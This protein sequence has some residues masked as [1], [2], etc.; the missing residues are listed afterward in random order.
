MLIR[1]APTMFTD[2]EYGCCTISSVRAEIIRN[3]KFKT[4]YPWRGQYYE[5][6][7]PLPNSLFSQNNSY[8]IYLDTVSVLNR[9]GTRN[10]KTDRL[11]DLSPVDCEI[12]ACALCNGFK[13][14]TG[15]SDIKD[16]AR[17]EFQRT[18]RGSISPLGLVN[19]WIKE[20]LI[21]WNGSFHNHLADWSR[22]NED[23]QPGR[24]KKMFKKL[25]KLKY[26]GS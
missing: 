10:K 11:F 1:I 15:D 4:K 6:I 21:K 23:S 18:Y 20:R 8:D 24:Q 12:L 16:F 14:T 13:I 5:K 25:T 26:P 7:K 22:L 9:Q 19:A 2:E 17:Q 3:Q